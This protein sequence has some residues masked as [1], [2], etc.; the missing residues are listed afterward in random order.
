MGLISRVS[1]RTYRF[2]FHTLQK[3][4]KNNMAAEDNW[5]AEEVDAGVE[6]QVEPMLF[7]KWSLSDVKC[8]DLSLQDYINFKGSAAKY[9]PHSGGRYNSKKMLSVRIVKHAFEIIAVMTGENPV[10]I[11]VSAIMNGGPRE[12]STRIGRA[13][14]VRRQAC[15]VSPMRRVNQAIWLLT[16]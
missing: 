9:L 15:D 11:L 1:S 6:D 12:D 7:G 10:Q 3:I 14:S 2:L 16:T 13:G 4:K 5:A 8:N